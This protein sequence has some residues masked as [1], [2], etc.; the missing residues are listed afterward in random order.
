[1]DS[2]KLLSVDTLELHKM[3]RGDEMKLGGV[4]QTATAGTRF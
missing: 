4:P 2:I 3:D 1:M